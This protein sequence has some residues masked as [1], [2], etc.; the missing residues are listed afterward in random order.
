MLSYNNKIGVIFHKLFFT[1]I[2][3]SKGITT[4]LRTP[5]ETKSKRRTMK[6]VK[7]IKLL[8]IIFLK[9]TY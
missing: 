4:N 2:I 7:Q 6:Q 9:T 3:K 5:I 8:H 1:I